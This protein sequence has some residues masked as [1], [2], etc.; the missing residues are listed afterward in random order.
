[1]FLLWAI[2][3]EKHRTSTSDTGLHENAPAGAVVAERLG[4]STNNVVIELR[5]KK[6][7]KT[8]TKKL[9]KLSFNL[10]LKQTFFS[11]NLHNKFFLNLLHSCKKKS[12]C[13]FF[14]LILQ[15]KCKMLS[16][17]LWQNALQSNR[18]PFQV[19]Y[20]I[21]CTLFHVFIHTDTFSCLFLVL[22]G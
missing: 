19:H 18:H 21:N 10:E 6:Q 1:M 8:H 16:M 4:W 2:W 9:S 17:L 7:N 20:G 14:I 11:A 15:N 3:G 22:R 5:L 13:L 12:K